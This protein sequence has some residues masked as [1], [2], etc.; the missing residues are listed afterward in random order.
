MP[1]RF[2]AAR[3]RALVPSNG[4]LLHTLRVQHPWSGDSHCP[5]K[6]HTEGVDSNSD[7]TTSFESQ[8]KLDAG[9]YTM[10]AHGRWFD[11]RGA[12]HDMARAVFR[13]VQAPVPIA[14]FI[15]IGLGSFIFIVASVAAVYFVRTHIRRVRTLERKAVAAFQSQVARVHHACATADQLAFPMCCVTYAH[16]KSHGKIISYEEARQAHYK[17]MS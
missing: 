16:F 2:S 7:H 13:D 17:R 15:S 8:V 6:R 1:F 12:K 4:W 10:I 9:G 14:V 5:S 11:C 3:Q